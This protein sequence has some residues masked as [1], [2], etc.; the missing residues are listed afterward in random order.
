MAK[1]VIE[2]K[3]QLKGS[4]AVEGAKNHA[5]KLIGASV[6]SNQEMT[7]ERVP[8]IEDVR[9][10]LEILQ[11]IGARVTHDNTAGI[12][13]IDPSFVKS[14]TI[15]E[16]T[17]GKIRSS[18]ILM[19]P[20]LARFGKVDMSYPGGCLL[21]RRPID[22]FLSGFEKMGARIKEGD[23]RLVIEA[24]KL[25]GAHIFMP[26]VSH[27][28]TEALMMAATLADGTTTI[29]NAAVEPEVGALADYLNKQGAKISGAG[30]S[31][32]TI[33]GVSKL[34]AGTVTTIPDRLET[35]TFALLAAA[36]KS[37][38]TITDCDPAHVGALWS[39]FDKM[40]VPYE[41]SKN[42]VKIKAAGKKTFASVPIRTHE[43]PG[44][45]TDIQAPFTVLLTQCE[46]LSLVHETIFEG[47]LF[48][49]D[50]LNRMGAN[51]ILCDPHRAIVQGPT[52]LRGK[53]LESPDIRAGI[54]LII[55]GLLAEGTTTIDNIYQ[56]ERG[57][58]RIEER[59]SALGARIKRVS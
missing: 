40:G 27:T 17:A 22:L 47:R 55:A 10:M 1:F 3:Q 21:G 49:T 38:I 19:G 7:I 54:G 37:N 12:V 45:P 56:V 28:V 23:D 15:P 58:A 26:I 34:S 9:R 42:S 46:G 41:L 11:A 14:G 4:I 52:A 59:L 30:S 20:L 25:K 18:T 48:Y 36:T 13:H 57:Y 50:K 2:G 29:E 44:F 6:L 31:V 5:L 53:H 35:A 8:D 32:I 39:V 16:N 51:I 43:Y 24:K 33:K